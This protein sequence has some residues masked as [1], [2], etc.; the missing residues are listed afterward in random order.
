MKCAASFKKNSVIGFGYFT[1]EMDH[2]KDMT[3]ASTKPNKLEIYI[4]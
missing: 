2:T 4:L 3:S 1:K